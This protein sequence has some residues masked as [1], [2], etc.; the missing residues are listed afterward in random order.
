M[1]EALRGEWEL[2]GPKEP[3]QSGAWG[4]PHLGNA[5]PHSTHMCSTFS[6]PPGPHPV[7]P[8]TAPQLRGP[9]G[10]SDPVPLV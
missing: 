10:T 1:G 3:R 4:G 9:K 2:A 8:S 5:H 6:L 7:L